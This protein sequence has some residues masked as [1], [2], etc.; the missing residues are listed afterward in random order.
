MTIQE[1]TNKMIDKT[2]IERT[3]AKQHSYEQNEV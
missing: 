1:K 3:K 2:G